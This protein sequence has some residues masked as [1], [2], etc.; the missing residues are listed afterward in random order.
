MGRTM[1]AQH[2]LLFPSR[3]LCSNPLEGSALIVK[4]SM[5]ASLDVA[6]AFLGV[7]GSFASGLLVKSGLGFISL[8]LLCLAIMRACFQVVSRRAW[9]SAVNSLPSGGARRSDVVIPDTDSGSAR[10]VS[11]SLDSRPI[12][13]GAETHFHFA[14]TVRAHSVSFPLL[15]QN[16]PTRPF[17]S[18]AHPDTSARATDQTLTQALTLSPILLYS[19]PTPPMQQI[20][21][22]AFSL[23]LH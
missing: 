17:S 9:P 22:Q 7:S 10:A 16:H 1:C 15:T 19:N 5:L 4:W 23:T 11:A 20:L 14:A 8:G 18:P 2:P 12:R 3:S 21:R 13:R 6:E